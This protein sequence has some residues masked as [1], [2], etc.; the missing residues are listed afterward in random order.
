VVLGVVFGEKVAGDIGQAG[1]TGLF[2]FAGYV[3]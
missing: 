1:C 2:A 3:E